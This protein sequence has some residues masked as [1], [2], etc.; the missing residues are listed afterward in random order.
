MIIRKYN[1][2]DI[3]RIVEL[4]NETTKEC[5]WSDLND[6]Q[7]NIMLFRD[8]GKANKLMSSNIALVLEVKE[9]IIG[10]VTM[11][12]QGYINF[13]YVDKNELKKGYGKSLLFELEKKA[14]SLGLKNIFLYASKYTSDRSI[15]EKLGYENKSLEAYKILGV[16]FKGYKMEKE[17]KKATPCRFKSPI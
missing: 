6:E 10:F 7:K 2:N 8:I 16:E 14:N 3:R 12:T 15:Y 5:N 9:R 4:Y 11:T 17:I 13:F 1:K